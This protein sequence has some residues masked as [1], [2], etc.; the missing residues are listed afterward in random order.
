MG[1]ALA[2]RAADGSLPAGSEIARQYGR[3]ER[4]GRLVKN[5]GL[6]GEFAD[7]KLEEEAHEEMRTRKVAA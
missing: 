4:W 7:V 1:W 6:A 2:N 3:C 5:A